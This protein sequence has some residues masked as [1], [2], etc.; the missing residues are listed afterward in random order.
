MDNDA[1]GRLLEL[2]DSTNEIWHQQD[3]PNTE[4]DQSKSITASSAIGTISTLTVSSVEYYP[5]ERGAGKPLE[6]EDI[7][8]AESLSMPLSESMPELMSE[9]NPDWHPFHSEADYALALWM[10]DARLSSGAIDNFFKDTRLR[11]LHGPF[12]FNSALQLKAKLH[13]IKHSAAASGW[14]RQAFRVPSIQPDEA[15]RTY[16]ILYFDIVGIIR[17]LIG[18]KPFN[19]SINYAPIRQRNLDGGLI[20]SEMCTARW[21]WET[22]DK[23]PDGSTVVPVI[24]SS[25]KTHLSRTHGDQQAWPVYI[26]IGNLDRGIRRAQL[27]PGMMLLGLVPLVHNSVKAEVYHS[28]IGLMVE[29]KPAEI[30]ILLN[31]LIIF[32]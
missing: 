12:S 10:H 18:H 5:Q 13:T 27:R 17:T 32:F 20:V 30:R 24:I 4:L 22:Q 16:Y 31:M 2:T 11:P 21:W 9:S 19:S 1:P 7:T 3:K 29:G 28:A 23:L 6:E 14:S 15:T 25:D 26:T 8:L